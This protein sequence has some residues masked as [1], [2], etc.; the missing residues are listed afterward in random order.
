MS[1]R[2][3]IIGFMDKIDFEEE[4]GNDK[5]GTRVYPSIKA[6]KEDHPCVKECGIVEVEVSLRKVIQ[7][8]NFKN[9]KKVSELKE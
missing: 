5:K 4:L 7:E 6:L 9:T 3:I 2:F 8:T 1:N